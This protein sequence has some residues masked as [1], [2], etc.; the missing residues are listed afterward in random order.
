MRWKFRFNVTTI[1]TQRSLQNVVHGTT[2]VL[3]WHV[4]KLV[5]IVW[6]ATELQQGEISME[7]KLRAKNR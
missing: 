7:F 1:L 2:A 4:Q 6:P 5:A 3:S